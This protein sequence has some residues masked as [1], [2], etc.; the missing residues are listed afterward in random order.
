MIELLVRV[1]GLEQHAL[2]EGRG[3]CACQR[4]PRSARGPVLGLGT[5]L[6][7]YGDAHGV[8]AL[9]VAFLGVVRA[10]FGGTGAMAGYRTSGPEVAQSAG[11]R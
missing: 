8:E 7:M 9:D 1:S 10:P 2:T 3:D 5:R 11:R 6:S 4:T